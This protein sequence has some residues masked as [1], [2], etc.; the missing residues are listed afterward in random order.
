M[1]IAQLAP[2]VESVPPCGYGGTE[3]VVSLLTEELVKRGHEVTLFAAGDSVTEAHLVAVVPEGLR[4]CAGNYRYRW[5]AYDLRSLLKL[6]EMSG[7]FDVVHN[8]MGYQA[9]PFLEGLNCPVVSTNHNLV[10]DYCADVYK[11]YKHLPFVAIS[12]SYRHLNY[13]DLLNYVATIYNG[14]DCQIYDQS[15]FQERNYLLFLGRICHA[16][17]TLVAM[18]IARRLELPLKIGGKVDATDEEYFVNEV[19]PGLSHP[20][21]DFLGEVSEAEKIEL[22][23][24]AMAT[25]Y[26]IQWDEP[27]GLVMAE[28]LASGTP[29]V[30]LKRGSVTEIVTDNETGIVGDSPEELVQRFDELERISAN[31]CRQRARMLFGKERMAEQY[32]AVYMQLAESFRKETS[33]QYEKCS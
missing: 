14:I 32:E 25:I 29:V 23:R 7:E 10:S 13:P 18:E 5:Q 2:L 26:P 4:K 30:A 12:Q 19:K 20:L 22:Y 8:H 33:R 16:K 24:G 11:A 28:S 27:F 9:L 21:I 1:R 15:G 17:G 3:L 6:N 31:K